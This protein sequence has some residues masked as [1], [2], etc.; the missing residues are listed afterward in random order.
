MPWTRRAFLAATAAT[1]VVGCARD[2]PAAI[3][4]GPYGPDRF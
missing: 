3:D 4:L 1:A 2:E